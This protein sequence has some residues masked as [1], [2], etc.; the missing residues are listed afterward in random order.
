MSI[1]SEKGLSTIAFPLKSRPR[2]THN[3]EGTCHGVPVSRKVCMRR[4]LPGCLRHVHSHTID[5]PPYL[6]VV[7]EPLTSP[8]FFSEPK[9]FFTALSAVYDCIK[10]NYP[11]RRAPRELGYVGNI[12]YG[13]G[14][15]AWLESVRLL[16][17]ARWFLRA[18]RIRRLAC[19]APLSWHREW[20]AYVCSLMSA[21]TTAATLAWCAPVK[22]SCSI[23]WLPWPDMFAG[24]TCWS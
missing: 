1:Y 19:W 22:I 10:P 23:V 21:T 11:C 3:K 12:T 6:V 13:F 20:D 8:P 9:F 7:V 18:W 5:R 2:L 16:R 24:I 15:E 17:L 4:P 14:A